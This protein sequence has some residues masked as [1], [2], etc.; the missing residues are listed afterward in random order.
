[1]SVGRFCWLL[2]DFVGRRGIADLKSDARLIS[3]ERERVC[4]LAD[5]VACWLILLAGAVLQ[6]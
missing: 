4:L 2:A 5:F 6:I 1:M 3:H